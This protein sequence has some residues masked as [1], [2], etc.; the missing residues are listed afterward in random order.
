MKLFINKYLLI[1]LLLLLFLLLF[2]LFGE[3]GSFYFGKILIIIA[4]SSS[5]QLIYRYK[6]SDF[7]VVFLIFGIMYWF[8]LLAYY[9][10]EIPYHYL[11]EY[12]TIEYTNMVVILQLSLLRIM[13]IGIGPNQISNPRQNIIY[14]NNDIVFFLFSS[15][16]IIMIAIILIMTPLNLSGDYSIETKSS[17]LLEYAIIFIIIASVYAHSKYKQY[18]IIGLSSVY[19]LL[20][21]LYGKRLAFLMISLL[22]FNLFF[23]GKFKLKYILIIAIIGFIFVRVFAGIRVGIE[24]M[25]L[26]TF[27]LGV[28]DDGVMSNNHGGV[29][30]CSVTYFGLIENDIFNLIFRLKSLLG[31][32]IGTILPASLNLENLYAMKY[33]QIPGNGGLTSIYLYIWGG[34]IGIVFGGLIFNY[35]IRNPNNS[36]LI[37]IYLIFM[38]ATYPRWYAYNMFILLKMGFWLM[39]FLA[40]ADTLH[41]Y[42]KKGIIK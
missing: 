39:V 30:V 33:T 9:F 19:M 22:I 26:L 27:L 36:R 7:I 34:F 38:F 16:L 13:F 12:Q 5:I 6:K 24:N 42:T 1:D 14:R 3:I 31:T 20:P 29:V 35:L 28:T 25:N 15:I 37:Y 4:I 10:F 8:Y 23:T 32:V 21:L 40:M 17:S 41:K 11:L 18:F 2:Y